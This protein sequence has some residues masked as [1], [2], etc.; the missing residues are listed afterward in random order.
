MCPTSPCSGGGLPPPSQPLD[1]LRREVSQGPFGLNMPP[2]SKGP[3]VLEG[4]RIPEMASKMAQHASNS[5]WLKI[6]SDAHPRGSK[7]APIRL[8]APSKRFFASDGL[9]GKASRWPLDAPNMAQ[10]LEPQKAPERAPGAKSA[11]KRS[12]SGLGPRA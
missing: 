9:L 4:L 7:T 6:A 3:R 8:Q 5:S 2:K 11:P 12:R 10:W 1:G